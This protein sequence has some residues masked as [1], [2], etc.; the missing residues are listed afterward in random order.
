[1]PCT[2]KLDLWVWQVKDVMKAFSAN[3]E[4]DKVMGFEN[5]HDG[6]THILNIFADFMDARVSN[7]SFLILFLDFFSLG[8][9]GQ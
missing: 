6:L 9:L 3:L 4:P 1:M 8:C 7:S 5:P 2:P